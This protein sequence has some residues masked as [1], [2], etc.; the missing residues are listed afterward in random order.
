MKS[1]GTIGAGTGLWAG[2]NDGATNESGF[3][4]HPG[5]S[6]WYSDGTFNSALWSARFATSTEYDINPAYFVYR[7]LHTSSI[8]VD[9]GNS[10][11][12]NGFSVRCIK[13]DEL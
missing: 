13:N 9:S 8:E 1:T 10:D 3:T 6:R 2:T 11:K 4:A 5:G 12:A 7:S